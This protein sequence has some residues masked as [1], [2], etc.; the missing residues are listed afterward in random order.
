MA[1]AFKRDKSIFILTYVCNK[2]ISV[3]L[4]IDVG[5][6]VLVAK[7]NENIPSCAE[8]FSQYET[9]VVRSAIYVDFSQLSDAQIRMSN[10]D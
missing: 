9:N 3:L 5:D 1:F 10:A 8:V 2:A 6:Y 4:A 7:I